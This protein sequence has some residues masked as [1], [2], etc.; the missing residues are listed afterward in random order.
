MTEEKENGG[1]MKKLLSFI[2]VAA[3]CTSLFGLD[4]LSYAPVSGNVKNFTQTDFT[5]TSKFGNYFRTPNTKIVRTLNTSGK[6]VELVELSPK[7]AV[8]EKI[9]S[10][11]DAL[12]NLTEQNC[13]NAKQELIWKTVTTYNG[14]QKVDCSEYGKDGTLK[15][16]IIYT[17]QNGNLV[18][19]TGYDGEGALIWKIVTKHDEANRVSVISE[20][21]AD[22]S[23]DKE[24]TYVYAK[25]GKIDSITVYDTLKMTKE[26]LV[27]KYAQDG[28]ISQITTY[29]DTK[30]IIY[31]VIVKYDSV[32]NVAKVS[33]YAIAQKFGTTV[34]D[35]VSVTEFTY[36]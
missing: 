32:G 11:Y 18:D 8:I 16:K 23:L 14:K 35:L 24:T 1:F 27:F 25:N 20:Y 22:G 30:E 29:D 34:N 19:E 15:E 2:A 12:G 10:S 28:T 33:E 4:I 26:Q 21:C 9:T 5:I 17:Y 13:Y 36:Q 31:R 3:L 7:D 6:E